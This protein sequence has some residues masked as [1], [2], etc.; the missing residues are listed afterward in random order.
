MPD[1]SAVQDNGRSGT[2]SACRELSAVGTEVSNVSQPPWPSA[3]EPQPN[4]IHLNAEDAE[5][6]EGR[7]G[8]EEE[9]DEG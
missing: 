9:K 7:R 1:V 4:T 2:T 6:A 3:A 8:A 5:N